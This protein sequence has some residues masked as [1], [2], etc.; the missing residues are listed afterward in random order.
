T[1]HTAFRTA[2]NPLLGQKSATAE[3]STRYFGGSPGDEDKALNETAG[4]PPSD[5]RIRVAIG[6]LG[7]ITKHLRQVGPGECWLKMR[8]VESVLELSFNTM[9]AFAESIKP[10]Q[11]SGKRL[12][13]RAKMPKVKASQMEEDDRRLQDVRQETRGGVRGRVAQRLPSTILEGATRMTSC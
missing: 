11:C 10:K 2:G 12:P 9:E 7:D 1:K 13:P 3:H 8:R 4:T 6:N 5:S